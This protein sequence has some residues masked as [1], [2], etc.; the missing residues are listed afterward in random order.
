[1]VIP[2]C[3]YT[4]RYHLVHIHEKFLHMSVYLKDIKWFLRVHYTPPIRQ[5]FSSSV[6]KRK[7]KKKGFMTQVYVLSKMHGCSVICNS[8]ILKNETYGFHL[9]TNLKV[10]THF[11]LYLVPCQCRS[12]QHD[13]NHH[14]CYKSNEF[15]KSIRTI[16]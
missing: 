10:K 15:A 2:F 4:C 16:S 12:C 3:E 5:T 1:M 11:L 14:C 6:S 7:Y 8:A 9:P 13:R